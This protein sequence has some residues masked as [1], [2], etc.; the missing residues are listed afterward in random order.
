MLIN[1]NINAHSCYVPYIR[2]EDF[3]KR[4]GANLKKIRNKKGMSQEYIAFNSELSV[5]QVGRIERGE[6]NT[7]LSTIYE[8]AQTINVDIK[9]LFDF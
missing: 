3:L 8:I 4:F 2:H 7:S 6:I 5:N 1:F 9:E